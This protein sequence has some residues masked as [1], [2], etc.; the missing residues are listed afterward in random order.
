MLLAGF[1]LRQRTAQPAHAARPAMLTGLGLI[2]AGLALFGTAPAGG[3]LIHA[4]PVT[5]LA[6]TG[7]GLCWR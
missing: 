7:A 4:F 3:Y 2:A 6:G 1:I 5:V